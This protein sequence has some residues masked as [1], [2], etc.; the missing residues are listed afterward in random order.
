LQAALVLS[1][2]IAAAT[3][4]KV[5]FTDVLGKLDWDIRSLLAFVVVAAFCIAAIGG[6]DGSHLLKDVALVVIG[7]YFGG[8]TI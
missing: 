6:S 1:I 7:F 4:F 8:L 3:F 2:A 5:D